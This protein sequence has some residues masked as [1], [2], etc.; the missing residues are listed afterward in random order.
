MP[1]YPLWTERSHAHRSTDFGRAG[2]K[3]TAAPTDPRISRT[4]DGDHHSFGYLRDPRHAAFWT[5]FGGAWNHAH[6]P[7]AHFGRAA[8]A[9]NQTVLAMRFAP[10]VI[11]ART[12]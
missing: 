7:W 6:A 9:G 8:M 10:Q 3:A 12:C 4:T 2:R 5:W 1:V 11:I